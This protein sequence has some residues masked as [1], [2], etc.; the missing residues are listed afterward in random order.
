MIKNIAIVGGDLRIV[1][2]AEMLRKEDYQVKTYA[3]EKATQIQDTKVDTLEECVKDA[4]IVLGPL[5]LSTNEQ[6]INAPFSEEKVQIDELINQIAGKTF[7]AGSVKQEVYEM[8]EDKDITIFDILKREELAVL[9]AI[10]TAEG[11]IQIAI[12][13]T[14]KNLHGNN[15]LVLGFG[16]IGKILS[17]MLDGIGAKVACEARKTTDL[18]WIKAYGYEPINLIELKENLN[19]FDIIINTIPYTL[20]NREMLQEV[21][22]DA[23]IIDLA[24]NPGGVD[25]QAVKEL[26]IKFNWALSLPGKVS[27]VTSAEFMKET[28]LNMFKEINNE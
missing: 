17:K 10:S 18:A 20:L 15:V 27:P 19:R 14:P 5:P 25:K 8:A 23:L 4:D 6:L 24:S 21:K 12:N 26:E 16:R 22:K 11:A 2:L 28:L 13:E 1:K 7:I 3:L 9:N